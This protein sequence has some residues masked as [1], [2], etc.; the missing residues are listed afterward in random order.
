MTKPDLINALLVMRT[1]LKKAG[2]AYQPA[3]LMIDWL[4]NND[5]FTSKDIEE[6]FCAGMLVN[7]KFPTDLR[8]AD[9]E[10]SFNA[11]RSNCNLNRFKNH[12]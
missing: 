5:L 12:K 4:T 8:D 9:F 7:M 11:F 6:A 3:D 1:V 10:K 2:L